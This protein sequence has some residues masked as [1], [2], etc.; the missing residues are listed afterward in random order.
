MLLGLMAVPTADLLELTDAQ[1]TGYEWSLGDRN[2]INVVEFRYDFDIAGATGQFGTRETYE[3]GGAS[4]GSIGKYGRRPALLIESRGIKTAQGG[5]ALVLNRARGVIDRFAEPPLV[6][7]LE[8]FYQKHLLEAGDQIR[9]THPN[10]PNPVTGLLGLVRDLFE[11]VD[12]TPDFARGRIRLTCLFLSAI[13]PQ[14]APVSG[15]VIS[16]P[17]V[18]LDTQA[19][20]V[21]TGLAVATTSELLADGT[22]IGIA[23][24]TWTANT[25]ADLSHYRL[26]WRRQGAAAFQELTVTAAASPRL[27]LRELSPN[28]I[29]EVQVAAVDFFLNASAFT[30]SATGTT[31]ADPGIP[32][33]PTGLALTPFPLAVVLAWTRNAESDIAFYELQRADD[34]P[35]T[36]NVTVRSVDVTAFVDKVG[37]TTT[38]FYRVRAV[39][40]TGATSAYSA[41][42]S[43]AGTQVGTTNLV[44]LAVT[45]AKIADLNVV[46]AKIA[47]LNVTTAKIAALAVDAAKI[48]NATI[49]QAKMA[50]ASIGTAEII[51]GNITT[52]KIGTAQI[53]SAKIAA[54]AVGTAEIGNLT[55]T[56]GKIGNFAV[57][58][59]ASDSVAGQVTLATAPSWTTL[60]TVTITP[61]NTDFPVQL[62]GQFQI[63]AQGSTGS[64]DG[65]KFRLLIDGAVLFPELLKLTKNFT[66]ARKF[67]WQAI[68]FPSVASHTYDLQGNTADTGTGLI[69]N[70]K[71][72]AHQ[73]KK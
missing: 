25:E 14:T 38:R 11:V 29:Y 41:S 55:V 15:G 30:A 59:V 47:D 34:A 62:D 72:S 12:V 63:D 69:S 54:L 28:T 64:T 45:T 24:V 8:C 48:A 16:L 31:P 58:V 52:A 5:A 35:F 53:T 68:D 27:I 22:F 42:V 26:R 71:M 18:Q 3:H 37:D 70:R 40:R 17:A 20:A 44:D 13:P 4:S 56:S 51:D 67:T 61:D 7:R 33:V 21:P 1:I 60:N 39:R 6:L 10:C 32:A 65:L 9:V 66:D 50:A 57:T 49:T 19:P 73:S 23:D 43:G 36:V 46:T 2:V